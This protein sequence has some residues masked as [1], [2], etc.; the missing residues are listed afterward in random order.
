MSAT[1]REQALAHLAAVEAFLS[2]PEPSSP[3]APSLAIPEP[4]P[5]VTPPGAGLQ[6]P[7]AFWASL[8]KTNILGPVLTPEEV[9]GTE[10]TLAAMAGRFP[11]SWAAYT[12]ATEY[13]E[14]AATMAPI[15]ERG[16][17]SYF[18]R[19]YDIQGDRPAKAR[20]LGNL[21]P[22]D[23]AKY[24]GRGEIQTTGKTN[25]LRAQT[26]LAKVGI[27]VDLVNHPEHILRQDA[28]TMA[29]ILG[30]RDGWYTGKALRDYI[31]AR[32]ARQHYINARRIVNGTD[33][34]ED[35]AD[36]ALVFQRALEAG[37]WL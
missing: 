20:E 31:P 14:T 35:I 27:I 36:I 16:G 29:M 37:R 22:G 30:M 6:D 2:Q 25:Y 34:A 23:G 8:R 12:L 3:P 18:R 1:T 10:Y 24:A 17:P 26:E 4:P 32:A 7:A 11:L 15:L 33:R 13:H 28:S 19:M 9:S 5:P 21:A